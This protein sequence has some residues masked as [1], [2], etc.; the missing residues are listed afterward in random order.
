[1]RI[2]YV[3]DRNRRGQSDGVR[4]L[5]EGNMSERLVKDLRKDMADNAKMQGT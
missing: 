5:S 3:T 1:M 4:R 2:I